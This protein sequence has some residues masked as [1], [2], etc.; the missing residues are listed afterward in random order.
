MS[1]NTE[2]VSDRIE[3]IIDALTKKFGT[4]DLSRIPDMEKLDALCHAIGLS[5]SQLDD[6]ISGNSPV[7]RTITGHVFEVFFDRLMKSNGMIVRTVGGDEAVDRIVNG[8]SIQLKT[9]TKSGTKGKMVMYKTHKTHGAK[10]ETE[11]EEYYHSKSSFPDLLVGLISYDPLRVLFLKRD[12]LPIHSSLKDRIKSPFTIEWRQHP[13]LNA[14]SELGLKTLI[15]PDWAKSLRPGANEPLPK[16]ASMIGLPSGFIL[17]AILQKENFRIWNMN[18]RGFAREVAFVFQL[19]AHD[20]RPFKPSDCRK[21]RADKAD[22]CLRDASTKKSVFFQVKGVTKD[23]CSYEKGNPILAIETQLSRGRVNDHPTQSRLY[24]ASDFDF[25]ILSLEPYTS[26]L[27]HVAAGQ[28]PDHGWDYY[29]IP[30]SRFSRH[31]SYPSRLKS[32]Q[33]IAYQEL[34]QYRVDEKWYKRWEKAPQTQKSTSW[35]VLPTL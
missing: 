17:D 14:W 18:I 16:T 32:M 24:Y 11:S 15:V 30:T 31:P 2:L 13:G 7:M 1:A 19:R 20:A 29:C 34:Q 10:S 35:F 12:S 21:D 6:L 9:P 4:S 3:D 25:L 33:K 8:L 28:T 27:C 23:Q 22:V 5:P 26:D